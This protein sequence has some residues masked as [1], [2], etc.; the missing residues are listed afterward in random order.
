[1]L[2]LQAPRPPHQT[3]HC[4][5][6]Q[7]RIAPQSP[8]VR[9]LVAPAKDLLCDSVFARAKRSSRQSTSELLITVLI[10]LSILGGG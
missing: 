4:N 7:P 9:S 1:M 2:G 8:T 10:H 6:V 3:E 5:E